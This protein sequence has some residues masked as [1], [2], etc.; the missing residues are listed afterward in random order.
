M[1]CFA[2]RP[3]SVRFRSLVSMWEVPSLLSPCLLGCHV[4]PQTGEASSP[5]TLL[6]ASLTFSLS[7][8]LLPISFLNVDPC[9]KISTDQCLRRF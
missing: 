4:L 8:K 6:V 2:V 5:L 9:Q 7:S 3:R 1:F